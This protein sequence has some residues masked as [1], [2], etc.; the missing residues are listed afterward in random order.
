MNSELRQIF[1]G[2]LGKNPELKY[3]K[4]QKPVCYLSV[5]VNDEKEQKTTWNKVVAWGKQA[6][7]A[8]IYPK[9]G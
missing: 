8:S 9:K 5:A 4:N 3:T 6:K 1:M 2:R 7:L